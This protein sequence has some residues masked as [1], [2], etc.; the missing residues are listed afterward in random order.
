VNQLIVVLAAVTAVAAAIRGTWSP[1]G[2][3]M[4]STITPLAER[5][6]SRRYGLTVTWF[7]VGGVAG[8]LTLGAGAALL[9]LGV[10]ATGLA[11]VAAVGVAGIA[12][13]IT[14]AS[15]LKV[16]G[17]SFWDHPRQ[18]N[19]EWLDRYRAWVYGVGFGWQIGA[20]LATY[21]MTAAVYLVVVLAALTASPLTALAIGA[22]FGFTRGSAIL[23]GSRITSPARL[24]SFHRRFAAWAEPVRRAVIGVQLAVAV[25]ACTAVWGLVGG[26]GAVA[27]STVFVGVT[28]ARS[29]ASA[30]R[31][32][33]PVPVAAP[34]VRAEPTPV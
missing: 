11:A 3:S 10:R 7:V 25:V 12:A 14:A 18:V 8:G 15:D 28:V 5:G 20:G 2:L 13:L 1:C 23:L 27:V 19:E 4:L 30:R 21:I 34:T 17:V 26:A 6:R 31:G 32:V 29:G 9:A 33:G 24:T 16:F 22:L